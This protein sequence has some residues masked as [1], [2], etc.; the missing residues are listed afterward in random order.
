MKTI[1]EK[2][3]KFIKIRCEK[4]KNEQSTFNKTSTNVKC[5]VCE[6]I[7]AKATGGKIKLTK[8]AKHMGDLE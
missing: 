8:N 7:L 2:R 5:L 3:S 6:E 1:R 4:C